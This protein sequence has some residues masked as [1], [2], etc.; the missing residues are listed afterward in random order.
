MSNP[1]Y[2]ICA[3]RTSPRRALGS[4][5]APSSGHGTQPWSRG[6]APPVNK[7]RDGFYAGAR[8]A[9]SNRRSDDDP[10]IHVP[11]A[12]H[13]WCSPRNDAPPRSISNRASARDGFLQVLRIVRSAATKPGIKGARQSALAS[14]LPR[15]TCAGTWCGFESGACHPCA[16]QFVGDRRIPSCPSH[17]FVRSLSCGLI[18]GGAHA[19]SK[20]KIG[21]FSG[22][23]FPV[24][25]VLRS[26]SHVC[27]GRKK[28]SDEAP[29]QRFQSETPGRELRWD[30]CAIPAISVIVIRTGGR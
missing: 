20:T 8:D 13:S 29:R 2:A 21:V 27:Q 17:R 26:R 10:P 6:M 5:R 22:S 16:F 19:D 9:C 28:P 11:A 1:L 12:D 23:G 30:P 4:S 14:A 3:G 25:R 7:S 15:F 24:K 18:G